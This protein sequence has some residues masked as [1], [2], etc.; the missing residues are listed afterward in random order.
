MFS[1]IAIEIFD[2]MAQSYMHKPVPPKKSP[3]KKLY[4]LQ[5]GKCYM[6]DRQ[7]CNYV[8]IKIKNLKDAFDASLRFFYLLS[9]Q[10]SNL[11]RQNQNLQCYH[12]TMRQT[13]CGFNKLLSYVHQSNLDSHQSRN[14]DSHRF[15]SQS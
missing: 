2:L 13:K 8:G 12:Y 11:D 14:S 4:I 3:L 10:D 1:H 6:A 9:H 5:R 15:A 7:R